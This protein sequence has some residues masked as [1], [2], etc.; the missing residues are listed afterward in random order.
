MRKLHG[1]PLRIVWPALTRAAPPQGHPPVAVAAHSERRNLRATQRA[2]A[3]VDATSL[4]KEAPEVV[5]GH[6]RV[7][8]ADKHAQPP[9]LRGGRS[10]RH[11]H[12]LRP[13]HALALDPLARASS[14]R[15]HGRLR[16]RPVSCPIPRVRRALLAAPRRSLAARSRRS[17]RGGLGGL[18]GLGG[19]G[20]RRAWLDP[21]FGLEDGPGVVPAAPA[22]RPAAT[23]VRHVQVCP[24]GEC[25]WASFTNSPSLPMSKKAGAAALACG[26]AACGKA[27]APP[28]LQ[29]SKCKGEAY[30]CKA[31]QV[32]DPGAP[33]AHSAPSM[34][35]AAPPGKPRCCLQ[36]RW[37][38]PASPCAA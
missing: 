13:R 28:L 4:P 12:R 25:S 16:R 20:C 6:V 24:A 37:R 2:R 8:V 18:G 21:A 17:D 14:A 19:H 32:G 3:P 36:R 38:P 26:N 5:F 22:R 9:A 29:C 10:R 11:G 31:C 7:Q 35:P 30:C 1:T 34:A 15:D 27:L 33:A 23:R